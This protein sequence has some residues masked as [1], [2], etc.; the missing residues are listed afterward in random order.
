MFQNKTKLIGLV[1]VGLILGS[2]GFHLF[3]TKSRDNLIKKVT[4]E[5]AKERADC[6]FETLEKRLE[7]LQPKL[8][9][10]VS[11]G[12]TNKF[13]LFTNG[14][15]T[16]LASEDLGNYVKIKRIPAVKLGM[17]SCIVSFYYFEFDD[18][19]IYLS[20]DNANGILVCGSKDN[21]IYIGPSIY[22]LDQ[23]KKEAAFLSGLR[24]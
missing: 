2:V 6:R 16:E 5:Q 21:Q 24:F 22:S 3:K 10:I 14:E 7:C 8:T 20:K 4:Q 19:Y 18:K 9:K 15:K 1:L 13:S 12:F 23:I 17:G 11:Q